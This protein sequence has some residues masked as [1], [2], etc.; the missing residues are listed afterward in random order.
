MTRVAD[1]RTTEVAAEPRPHAWIVFH[2]AFAAIAVV[3]LLAP[4]GPLGQRV[5]VL[6]LAYSIGIVVM[7]LRTRDP[8]LMT[9]WL[10]LAP[11]SLLM[12]LPDW[13]LSAELGILVFPD[14]GAPYIDT[15]PI[16]MA[17]MWTVALLPV[18]LI[19]WA[20]ERS[21]GLAAALVTVVVGGLVMFTL[22]EYAA[23]LIPLW[24]P[25]DVTQVA[26]VAPYVL[27]PEVGLTIATYVLV[28]DAAHR[29]QWATAGG[30]V[31]VPF[32]YLGMLCTAYQF[33]G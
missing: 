16:F 5:L 19:G 14:T 29:S 11:M 2:V 7:A 30:I 18:M 12:V 21:R 25:S 32:M 4:F 3:G 13:F 33:L 26:G 10:V 27:L 23:P 22:A 28:R 24:Y 6:V 31:A 20:V 17:F 1:H 8:V 9:F 15:M